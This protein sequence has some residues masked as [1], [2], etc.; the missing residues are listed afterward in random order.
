MIGTLGAS[1]VTINSGQG[2]D[3]RLGT[4]FLGIEPCASCSWWSEEVLRIEQ[5][6]NNPK[7]II[8]SHL[9]PLPEALSTGFRYYQ[10]LA[11]SLSLL[12]LDLL[13]IKQSL[14]QALDMEQ[15]KKLA[16]SLSPEV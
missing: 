12:Q 7:G 14:F 3:H 5:L 15:L 9:F 8:K 10:S 16:M 11:A 2:K 13:F 1:T 4:W 6:E